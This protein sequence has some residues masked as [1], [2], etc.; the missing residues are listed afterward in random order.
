[1][2]A[3]QNIEGR[4]PQFSIRTALLVFLIVA[5]V[6]GWYKSVVEVHRK[7]EELQWQ[8]LR[9]HS[10]I[11]TAKSRA[12]F[13]QRPKRRLS[14]KFG[15]SIVSFEGMNLRGISISGAQFQGSSFKDCDLR[16]ATLIGGGASFQGAQFDGANLT[17]ATLTGGGASFQQASFV[18]ADLSGAVLTGNLQG[19]SFERAKLVGAR[20]IVFSPVEFQC[21]NIDGTHFQAADLSAIAP[22]ALESCYFNAPPLYDEKTKFPAGFDPKAQGWSLVD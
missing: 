16:D 8:L 6:F 7:N 5:L 14:S 1:M 9:A 12:E 19:A 18:G 13:A 3:D 15:P 11:E 10:E 17:N 4:R 20:V 21:A 2:G 22:N